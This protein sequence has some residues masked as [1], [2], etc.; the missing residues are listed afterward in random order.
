MVFDFAN[1]LTVAFFQ[2][3]GKVAE[4]IDVFRRLVI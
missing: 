2:L 1:G 3:L 4:M